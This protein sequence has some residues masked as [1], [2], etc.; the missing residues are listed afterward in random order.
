[1]TSISKRVPLGLM[2]A[3]TTLMLL[4]LMIIVSTGTNAAGVPGTYTST[5]PNQGYTDDTYPAKFIYDAKLTLTAGGSGSFWLKC[6]NVIVHQSGWVNPSDVIGKSQTVSVDYTVSGSSVTVTVQAGTFSFDM[7]LTASGNRLSGSGSYTDPSYVTNSWTLDVTKSGSSGGGGGSAAGAPNVGGLAG[8][9]G[10]GGFLAGFGASI[11]PPPRYMGGSIMR[12]SKSPL[13]TPYAPSQS[14]VI[15]HQL[16]S[17]ANQGNVTRPLPDVPRMQFGPG[18]IQFPNVQM[19]QPTVVQPTDI[20]PTD[21]LAKRF[22]PNC[23]STLSYTAAG[24]GCQGCQR[25]PPGGLDPR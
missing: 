8:A 7:Q 21:V 22:C 13:G 23:G 17:M 1:M 16:S 2:I 20:P 10:I 4:S 12:P 5:T 11:L 3:G 18:P 6:T 15:N 9:A 24:W 25:A 14:V 19:G